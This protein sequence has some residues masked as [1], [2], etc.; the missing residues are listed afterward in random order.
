MNLC[1][2]LERASWEH[3]DK[4]AVIDADG[5]S[6]TYRELRALSKRIS[7]VLREHAGIGENDIVVTIIPDNH[8]HVAAFYAVMGMGGVFSGLNRKQNLEKFALDAKRSGKSCFAVFN[9]HTIAPGPPAFRW[10][11]DRRHVEPALPVL[12][13]HTA[14]AHHACGCT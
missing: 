13:F 12:S 8:L 10:R 2:W 6:V 11:R 14:R 1:W 3:P 5:A 4:A 7:N 9:R